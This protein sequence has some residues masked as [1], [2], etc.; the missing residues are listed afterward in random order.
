MNSYSLKL[1]RI[2]DSQPLFDFYF[3]AIYHTIHLVGKGYPGFDEW[4]FDKVKNGL[5]DGD[6]EVIVFVQKRY[7]AGIAVLKNTQ[8]EKKICTLRVLEK[9]Q[10]NGI[11]KSLISQSLE[12]LGTETPLITV[13]SSKETQFHS[14]FKHFGFKKCSELQDYYICN[15]QESTYNGI[16]L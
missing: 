6:R 16:L 14:L 8:E 5:I 9:F 2:V 4:F 7:I 3:D 10:R 12:I 15:E 1:S 11:G 13:S